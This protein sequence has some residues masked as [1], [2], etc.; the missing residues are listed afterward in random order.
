M[1]TSGWS[2]VVGTGSTVTDAVVVAAVVAVVVAGSRHAVQ[3]SW[4]AAAAYH[5]F[6]VCSRNAQRFVLLC[7]VTKDHASIPTVVQVVPIQLRNDTMPRC[8]T[9]RCTL[10]NICKKQMYNQPQS[11]PGHTY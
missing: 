7:Q 1:E 8:L 9:R 2:V 3:C 10:A 5:P 6:A 4:V 11:C